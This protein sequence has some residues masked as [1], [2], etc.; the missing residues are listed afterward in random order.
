MTFENIDGLLARMETDLARL[1]AA[2]DARRFFHAAY[3]RTT[4]AIA[5][6]MKPPTAFVVETRDD[7]ARCTPGYSK[8]FSGELEDERWNRS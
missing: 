8:Y 2:R 4:E 7:F 5:D 1:A 3:L 6:E